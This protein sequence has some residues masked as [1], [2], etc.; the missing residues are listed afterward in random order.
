MCTDI[1]ILPSCQFLYN[2]AFKCI[3]SECIW[4][5]KVRNTQV[6]NTIPPKANI[7]TVTLEAFVSMFAL[8]HIVALILPPLYIVTPTYSDHTN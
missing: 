6:R 2:S 5:V 3:H 4:V 1:V 7:R 8:T